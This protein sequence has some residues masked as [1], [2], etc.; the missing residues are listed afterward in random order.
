[1][2][3][4]GGLIGS[5]PSVSQNVASNIWHIRDA[6][7][8]TRS[9]NWPALPGAPTSVSVT[10]GNAQVSLTWTAPATNGGYAITDYTVQYSSNSGSSWTT[11]SRAASSAT[12]ATVTGLTN[13]TA[14]TFRVAAVTAIGAGS[15]STQSAVVTPSSGPPVTLHTPYGAVTGSG[16][17]Q[18]KWSWQS[19]SGFTSGSSAKLL[20]A[21]GSVTLQA[22]LTNTGGEN[23]DW[24]ESRNLYIYSSANVFVRTMSSSPETLTA[25]QY[26]Y[27][28]LQCAHARAEVWVV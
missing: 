19:G 23:C 15:Y 21:T 27:L 24:G 2:R 5:N 14:Y 9:G 16:T 4:R 22:T 28:G 18:S 10:A 11:F 13:G 26:I 12:S 25:G 6:E 3:V 8:Y 17:V 20:T 1:M 7:S